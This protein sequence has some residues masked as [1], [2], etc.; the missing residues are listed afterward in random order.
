MET[1]AFTIIY[2]KNDL[3]EDEYRQKYDEIL[4]HWDK[5][6]VLIEH[7]VYEDKKKNGDRTKLHVHGRCCIKRGVFRKKLLLDGFHIKLE[8]W[9]SAGW[10]EYCDKNKAVLKMFKNIEVPNKVSESLDEDG[11]KPIIPKRKLFN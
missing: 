9:R 8:S 2:N 3:T 4:R 7:I 1:W 10:T 11:Q 5:Y 6:N